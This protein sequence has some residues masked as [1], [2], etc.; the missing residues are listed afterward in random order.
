[1]W[2]KFVFFKNGIGGILK[3]KWILVFLGFLEQLDF[4]CFGNNI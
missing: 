3:K 2:N 1:M 4:N